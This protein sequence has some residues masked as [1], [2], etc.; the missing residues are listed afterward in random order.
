MDETPYCNFFRLVFQSVLLYLH[1]R[2]RASDIKRKCFRVLCGKCG[3]FQQRR[4]TMILSARA[5][6]ML[7]SPFWGWYSISSRV[8]S[9][10]SRL[11]RYGSSTASH[12]INERRLHTFVVLLLTLESGK[13]TLFVHLCNPIRMRILA[14]GN[15]ISHRKQKF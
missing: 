1:C 15:P 4:I 2:L 5:L 10:I 9:V 6:N 12:K 7:S 13:G 3:S 14:V 11:L 8:W